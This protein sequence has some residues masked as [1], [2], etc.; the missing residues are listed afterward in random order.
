MIGV[1]VCEHVASGSA[2]RRLANIEGVLYAE[3]G[4]DEHFTN[5]RQPGQTVL[6]SSEHIDP[7][8]LAI[9]R[10]LPVGTFVERREDRW[11]YRTIRTESDFEPMVLYGIPKDEFLS[12]FADI[13]G[14]KD[15]FLYYSNAGDCAVLRSEFGLRSLPLWAS[16][17]R[18][19]VVPVRQ[20]FSPDEPSSVGPDELEAILNDC[21]ENG[22]EFV[23]LDFHPEE[24][25][26]LVLISDLQSAIREWTRMN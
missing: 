20:K 19:F 22:I 12:D 3:C 24:P 11:E 13:L 5:L 7:D 21:L 2:I 14:A 18:A 6:R 15:W 1:W 8:C 16:Q 23:N 26:C 10:Q 25:Q 9:L 4:A 17:E